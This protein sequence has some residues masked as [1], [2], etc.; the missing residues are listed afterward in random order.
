MK[1]PARTSTRQPLISR[2]M[3]VGLMAEEEP[4]GNDEPR[5]RCCY[6]MADVA[7]SDAGTGQKMTISPIDGP[8]FRFPACAPC[9][10][11][12]PRRVRHAWP[13]LCR[14]AAHRR[15]AAGAYDGTWNVVFATT[16][17]NCSSGNSVPFTVIRQP[18]FIGRRRQGHGFG[19]RAGGALRSESRL[20]LPGRA[21]VAGS[22]A[23]RGAGRWS[24][25]I[26]GDRCSGTWQA[27]R[28]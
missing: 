4:I 16:R 7:T 26:T 11:S 19:S 8:I 9:A 15:R 3:K 28:S 22:P 24:G 27:T 6:L 10:G 23:T 2:A 18:R 12:D 5:N 14:R 21:A 13:R 17:G 20:A 25:I 1:Q